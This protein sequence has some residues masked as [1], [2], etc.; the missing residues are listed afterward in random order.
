MAEEFIIGVDSSTQSTKAVAWSRAG[1]ALGEGRAAIP[2][3]HPAKNQCE[4]DPEDWWTAFR[5][6]VKQLGES[7]DLNNAAAIAV[8]NQRETVGFIGEDG[9]AV[10]PG[11]VWIDE[12]ASEVKQSFAD[13]FGADKLHRITGKPVDITPVVYRLHWMRRHEPENLEKTA[14]IVDVHGFLSGRLTGE[15]TAS[16]TS[17]DPFGVFDVSR[18]VWS[19]EIIK[20]LDIAAEKFPKTARPGARIGE[21]SAAAAAETGLPEGLP[22]I[23]AG[24]DGQCA[25]LGV[26][27]VRKGVA[28]L[29]LGTALIAGAWDAEPRMSLSWRTMSSPTGEGYFLEGVLRAGTYFIDWFVKNAVAAEPGPETFAALEAE[30]AVIPA[31]SDGLLVSPFLSGCMNP[32]WSMDVRAAFI[33]MRPL[34]RRGHFYRAALESLTGWIARSIRDMKSEGV[35]VDTI[36]AVGGGAN[37]PLWLQMIADATGLPIQVS[38]S[39]EASS[40][41]AGMTAAAGVGWHPGLLSAAE[42]MS[43]FQDSAQPSAQN[44]AAWDDLMTRQEKLDAL[45]VEQ[46][47]L[48]K[49]G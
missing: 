2:M 24:G 9:R 43:G 10:R 7:V 32:H 28:Y 36:I 30:A 17:A 44:R 21:V 35:A 27:A 12:R 14:A 25:G 1:G 45:L 47:A 22:M 15:I 19:P 18:K 6:A 5:A 39:A 26:N 48:T 46:S 23:A 42:A 37:S 3:S 29:N 31:G 38:N 49:V 8:S 11:I 40:L 41:G 4:Q 13:S 34:H 20:A 16:W 33:G